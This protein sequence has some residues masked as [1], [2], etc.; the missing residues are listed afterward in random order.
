MTNEMKIM[1]MI[2]SAGELKKEDYRI[3]C[4]VLLMKM[5]INEEKILKMIMSDGDFIEED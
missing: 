5:R 1:K 2:R 3:K 4:I